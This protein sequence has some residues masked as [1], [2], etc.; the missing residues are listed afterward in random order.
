MHASLAPFRHISS[1]FC[2]ANSK[3][4]RRPRP[5]LAT[6]VGGRQ[7]SRR[8]QHRQAKHERS[9][10]PMKPYQRSH[11]RR[12]ARSSD[13]GVRRP[14]PLRKNEAIPPRRWY[15]E[16]PI[17]FTRAQSAAKSHKRRPGATGLLTHTPKVS[18]R[19][20]KDLND[21]GLCFSSHFSSDSTLIGGPANGN[22]PSKTA[23]L[24]VRVAHTIFPT[25]SQKFIGRSQPFIAILH[26]FRCNHLLNVRFATR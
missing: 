21:T 16:E 7:V 11:K 14:R 8:P 26:L 6:T 10:V 15:M 2:I 18:V 4:P 12:H 20:A 9:D 3:L 19:G 5:A 1:R 17:T 24:D 13:R 25:F 22:E 23:A